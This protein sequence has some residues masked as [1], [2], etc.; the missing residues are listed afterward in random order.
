MQI[1]N[2]GL[3][4]A[5]YLALLEAQGGTCALTVCDKSVN[6][7]GRAL[8]IDHDHNCCPG[9]KSCGACVIGILCHAHNIA[10]GMCHND[11]AEARALAEYME[12]TAQ[13]KLWVA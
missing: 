5:Q 13:T 6:D 11:P 7:N 9:T 2:K 8:G 4:E 3:T 12:A 10:R 1:R